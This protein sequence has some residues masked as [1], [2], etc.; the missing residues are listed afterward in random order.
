M[1]VDSLLFKEVQVGKIF[2]EV[3]PKALAVVVEVLAEKVVNLEALME[4]SKERVKNRDMKILSL[5]EDK[6]A[7]E[8]TVQGLDA[9]KRELRA[10]LEEYKT[11]GAVVGA[12]LN[13]L[14]TKKKRGR[15]PKPNKDGE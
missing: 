14:D 11:P 9:E 6:E 12:L 1:R 15:Q 7:L 3:N 2:V 4:D 8:R 10:E 5:Q 13:S